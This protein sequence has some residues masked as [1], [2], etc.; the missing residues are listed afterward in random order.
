MNG[1]IG[2]NPT[3]YTRRLRE[4]QSNVDNLPGRLNTQDA[5]HRAFQSI[6]KQKEV[7]DRICSTLETYREFTLRDIERLENAC[8][9][10]IIR[11]LEAADNMNLGE[12]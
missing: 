1:I 5:D 10:F 7:L 9:D 3:E 6:I 8:R 12:G 2:I 4:L 11:D